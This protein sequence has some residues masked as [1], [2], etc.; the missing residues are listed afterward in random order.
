MQV[1][2]GATEQSLWQRLLHLCTCTRSVS[3]PYKGARNWA[4]MKIPYPCEGSVSKRLTA[5]TLT[6]NCT[7][8]LCHHRG[9]PCQGLADTQYLLDIHCTDKHSI[10]VIYA[11]LLSP[12]NHIRKR[13]AN[14]SNMRSYSAPYSESCKYSSAN[15]KANSLQR[16]AT[17]NKANSLQ[18]QATWPS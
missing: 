4:S 17:N 18:R 10:T 11:I 7:D 3:S 2:G 1:L 12:S 6:Q 8:I 9:C 5:I 13:N 15:T 14:T 16:Q